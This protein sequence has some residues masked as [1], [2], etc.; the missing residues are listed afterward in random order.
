MGDPKRVP[1]QEYWPD[2]N[3][4]RM[5]L[6]RSDLE[7]QAP[8]A[9]QTGDGSTLRE[10]KADLVADER[11]TQNEQALAKTQAALDDKLGPAPASPAE[12]KMQNAY[13]DA[14]RQ[15]LQKR[16]APAKKGP[17]VAV[18]GEIVKAYFARR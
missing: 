15:Q 16:A 9:A 18:L 5:N 17:E 12:V 11:H 10:L 14:E 1:G 13:I 7:R 4:P 8:V 6:G 3:V 2:S